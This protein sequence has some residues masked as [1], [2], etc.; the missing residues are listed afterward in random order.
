MAF[1]PGLRSGYSLVGR[2]V[3]FGR[4]LDKIRLNAVGRLPADYHGNLGIGFD[5]RTCAFLAINYD[6]LKARVLAGGCDEEILH[7]AHAQG[8]PRTEDQCIQWNR[9]MTKI[10][11]RDDRAPILRDRVAA[12][13]MTDKP[14]ETFFDLNEFDEGRDPV[15]GR[16][17]EF[18]EPRVFLLMGVAGSGKSTVGRKLAESLG[19]RFADADDFH[20][21]ANVAKIAS[22][23][24]LTD[25]DRA[26]WLAELSAFIKAR[27]AARENTVLACSALKAA[28]RHTLI[29]DPGCVK[30]V[31]LRGSP[32]LIK[33]RLERRQNHWAKPALLASQ[34]EALEEPKDVLTLD[35]AP[36]PEVLVTAIRRHYGL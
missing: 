32:E 10:G 1:T 11:W 3:Y 9:F 22:G 26:P 16:F 21:P 14:I 17:W 27:I 19:W 29:E 31:F 13:G 36:P 20:P 30:L 34:L 8:G 12:L 18:N 25:D 28:Y 7:W 35:I 6:L 15:A 33:T 24:P 23:N 4:M 2:I 5:A